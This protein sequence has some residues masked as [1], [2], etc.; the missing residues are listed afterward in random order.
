MTDFKKVS[1][2]SKEAMTF[3]S[4]LENKI[5]VNKKAIEDAPAL[6]NMRE[7]LEENKRFQFMVER[8]DTTFW[9]M[10]GELK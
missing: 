10:N 9:D 3:I 6:M 1:M 4:M 5:S 2:T 8:L 7:E